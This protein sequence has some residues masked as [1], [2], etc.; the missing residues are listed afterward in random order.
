[1]ATARVTVRRERRARF[2]CRKPLRGVGE[3]HAQGGR[4]GKAH[5]VDGVERAHEHDAAE[6]R[7]REVVG[8]AAGRKNLSL[9]R[10]LQQRGRV[11]RLAEQTVH[12]HGACNGRRRASA[13]PAGK[14]EPF[15]DGEPDAD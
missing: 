14:R 15:G 3:H 4:D 8:V 2:N 9:E 7:R 10:T 12:G 13:L 6:Q 5:D 1:M 11:E